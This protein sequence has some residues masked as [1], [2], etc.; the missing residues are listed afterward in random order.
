[1]NP[2]PKQ[3]LQFLDDEGLSFKTQNL[4]KPNWKIM[5]NEPWGTNDSK[6]RCGIFQVLDPETRRYM[7]KFNSFK[8]VATLDTSYRGSFWQFVKLLKEFNSI[9]ESKTWFIQNYMFNENLKELLME[10]TN[11]FDNSKNSTMDKQTHNINL[12][13]YYGRLANCKRCLGSGGNN[14]EYIWAC[15]YLIGRNI[16]R[17]IFSKFKIFI[18]PKQKRIVFPVYENKELIFY[19][20]RSVN[21]K[22]KVP[23]LKSAGENLFPIW[24]L[25]NVNGEII[26]IFEG[27]FDAMLVPNSVAVLGSLMIS[28]EK[29]IEKILYKNYHRINLIFDNDIAGQKARIETAKI[30]TEKYHHKNV[31]IYNFNR[32][33]EKDFNLMKQHN[34]KFDF[35]SRLIKWSLKTE[36]AFSLGV[37]K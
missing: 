8:A 17:D 33:K 36:T 34:I 16:S 14:C 31:W 19:T 20:G 12:P 10:D 5:F 27:I 29:A 6:F 1:M 11:E 9:A 24:N 21:D 25:E 30:L 13:D 15:N 18:D 37:I 32:I 22:N 26:N 28:N 35:N 7:V 3:I 4:D 2:N 23:W